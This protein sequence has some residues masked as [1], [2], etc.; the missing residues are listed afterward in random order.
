MQ[1]ERDNRFKHI[2]YIDMDNVLVDFQSGLDKVPQ[3]IKAQYEDD[4]K[5]T[6]YPTMW[7]RGLCN[8]HFQGLVAPG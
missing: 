7:S 1:I 4:G 2:I 8:A 5:R 3:E 6:I